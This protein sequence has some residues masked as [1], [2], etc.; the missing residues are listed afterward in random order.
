MTNTAFRNLEIRRPRRWLATLSLFV[1][2]TVLGGA[3]C[4]GR[5]TPTATTT[6]AAT[7]PNSA[8]GGGECASIATS[9]PHKFEP[10]NYWKHEI[11]VLRD[12]HDLQ[13]CAQACVANPECKVATFVDGSTS[14]DYRHTC[15]LRSQVGERHPE[16]P[17]MCSWVKS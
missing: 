9:G 6:G 3:A 1:G 12:Q 7:A 5:T 2:A 13:A 11:T 8:A 10:G 14:G 16:E 15:V 17:G 4:K